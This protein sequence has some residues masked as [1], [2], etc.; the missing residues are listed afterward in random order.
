MSE[1]RCQILGVRDWV[2]VVS[3]RVSVIQ[4]YQELAAVRCQEAGVRSGVV[5]HVSVVMCRA[6]IVGY[7]MP[8]ILPVPRA[9]SN[10]PNLGTRPTNQLNNY[11]NIYSQI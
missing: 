6:S 7:Q 8:I 3:C 5:C 10:I 9:D 11:P 1:I 4:R 2:S